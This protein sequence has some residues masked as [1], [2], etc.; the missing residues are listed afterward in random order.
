MS[1]SQRRNVLA[2]QGARAEVVA[3]FADAVPQHNLDATAW[4]GLSSPAWELAP[5]GTVRVYLN[6]FGPC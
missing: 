5:S 2:V 1:P 4:Y 3:P 6:L